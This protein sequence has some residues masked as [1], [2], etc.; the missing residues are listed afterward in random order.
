MKDSLILLWRFT[1]HVLSIGCYFTFQQRAYNGRL[2]LFPYLCVPVVDKI[3]APNILPG[4]NN[5][6]FTSQRL[7]TNS[8]NSSVWLAI[9]KQTYDSYLFTLMLATRAPKLSIPL[10]TVHGVYHHFKP[11]VLAVLQCQVVLAHLRFYQLLICN[12]TSRE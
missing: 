4:S 7:E 10:I 2:Q 6:L 1:H 11:A 3:E 8:N 9:T 12:T 5:I